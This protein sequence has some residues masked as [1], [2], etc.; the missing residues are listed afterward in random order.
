MYN[1]R[2]SW[3]TTSLFV[4]LTQLLLL[5][6]ALGIDISETEWLFDRPDG[7]TSSDEQKPPRWYNS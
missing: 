5:Q 4:K 7:G 2:L 3:F 1:K 6:L